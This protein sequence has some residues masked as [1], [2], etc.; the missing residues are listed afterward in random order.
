MVKLQYGIDHVSAATLCP[1]QIPCPLPGQ[2]HPI[3][4]HLH[5]KNHPCHH[6]IEKSGSKTEVKNSQIT[7]D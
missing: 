5:A 1:T 4:I 6:L 2:H 7:L 3:K